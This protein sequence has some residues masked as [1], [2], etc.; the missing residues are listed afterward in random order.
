MTLYLCCDEDRRNDVLTHPTLNGI[1]F[2]EVLD[3]DSMPLA[4]RQ[5]FLDATLLKLPAAPINEGN[6]RI[7]GGEAIRGISIIGVSASGQVLRV[8]V[9]R[10]GDFTPYTLRLV[11]NTATDTPP[12]GYDPLLSAV[13]FSFKVNCETEFDCED[14]DTCPP[15]VFAEPSLNMLA[16]DFNSIRKLMLDRI[17]VIAPDWREDHLADFLQAMVDLKAYVSD[18]QHYQLDAINSE[19]YL[20]TAR[21]RISVRRHARLVD[22]RMHDGC[23]PRVWAHIQIDPEVS[24]GVTLP[25]HTPLLSRAPGV[26]VTFQPDTVPY[27]AALEQNPEFFET[28]HE[29]T[30]FSAHNE[31]CFH[32]W[33][34]SQCVL[35]R[36]AT[37]ATLAGAYPDLQPGDVL[38]FEEVRGPVT[39]DPAD[40]DPAKRFALRL[41]S[42]A[43]SEDTL[44]GQP[45]TEIAWHAEDALPT[46]LCL[47]S[48][49][50]LSPEAEDWRCPQAISVARGNMV[51][52][53]HGRL[54][55]VESL[56]IVPENSLFYASELAS[57]CDPE[58]P[59]AVPPR[60]RPRLRYAPV[61][62]VVAYHHEDARSQSASSA[63]RLNPADTLPGILLG[64]DDQFDSGTLQWEPLRDLLEAQPDD[65]NFVVEV[66]NDGGVQIRF[67][68]DQQGRRPEAGDVLFARYYVGD[69][70][71]GNIG[72]D[73]LG[74][75]VT[76]ST[77][78]LGVRN[79][80]PA[81]GGQLP[82]SIEVVRQ[83]APEAFRTQE[84]AVTAADYEDVSLRFS[85]VQR[86]AATFRWTGSWYTVYL[87][88]DR[89]GGAAITDEF[90]R[91]FRAHINRYRMMGYDVEIDAPH[92]VPIDLRLEVCV[93]PGYFRS[94]VERALREVFSGHILRNGTKGFFHP[95]NFTFGQPLYLSRVYAAAATVEGV[96]SVKVTRF[97]VQDQPVRSGLAA[98]QIALGRLEIAQLENDPSFPKRGTF[99]LI[100]EGGK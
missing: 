53:Q 63:T 64:E 87:T 95:D 68:D 51:L 10:A 94:D 93:A 54:M 89:V 83:N 8:E 48:N 78:V 72:A 55:T 98:G 31:M 26:P 12:P 14:D 62:Q 18:Y 50:P 35:P 5:R 70:Q 37:R 71:A 4:D 32:T 77:S 84:R 22:H 58:A 81:T 7:D 82:E 45:V 56:G 33:G 11:A 52:A 57:R 47:S 91:D 100:M 1:D 20:F 13:D 73:A 16:R 75:V 65:R 23:S 3:D 27:R 25:T 97:E 36:G 69:P 19:A 49:A 46:P 43:L 28:L 67:G 79:P 38:I 34:D 21:N 15:E 96:Q 30:G 41:I 39:G 24:S 29:V 99:S 66:D 2:V 85:G 88:V 61:T 42:V 90:E 9:D 86:A 76:N 80:M 6:L 59:D 17:H 40:A 44:Y 74:H 92:Y 60:F